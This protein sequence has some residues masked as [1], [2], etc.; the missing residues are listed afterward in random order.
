[1][2]TTRLQLF[3]TFYLIKEVVLDTMELVYFQKVADRISLTLPQAFLEP[4]FYHHLRLDKYQHYEDLKG[5]WFYALD[6]SQFHQFEIWSVEGKKQK[7]NMEDVHPN[8]TL[9]PLYTSIDAAIPS[10]E[11]QFRLTVKEKGKALYKINT[12]FNLLEQQLS[13]RFCSELKLLHT[14]YLK[15]QIILPNK[16]DTLVVG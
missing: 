6:I 13:F 8:R 4:F 11:Y 15:N 3:G 10:K 5:D 14:I 12:P 16:R 9:F 2:N 7:F 1:M